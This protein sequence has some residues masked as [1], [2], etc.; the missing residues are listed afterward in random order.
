MNIISMTSGEIS[1]PV[2]EA[3]LQ[4][5]L[6]AINQN[7]AYYPIGEGIYSLREQ[8]ARHYQATQADIMPENVL[9]TAGA[10]HA[11]YSVLMKLLCQTTGKNEVIVPA[12]YWFSLP[13]LIRQ[14]GGKLVPL[15]TDPEDDYRIDPKRLEA[16][17]TPQT[18]LFV[19]VNPCN[20]SGKIYSV[21]EIEAIVGVLE[22]HPHVH[23]LADEIYEFICFE[24]HEFHAHQTGETAS[25]V[26]HIGS[27][28]SV[29]DRVTTVSGF[30]KSFSMAGWRV[31]YIVASESLIQRY[32]EYQDLTHAG[33]PIY[34]Q[35]AAEV[36][37]QERYRYLPDVLSQLDEKRRQGLAI[38]KAI[39]GIKCVRPQ[40]T[41]YFF[42]DVSAFY[43]S[44]DHQGNP[45]TNSVD[46][47]RYLFTDARVRV[48]PGEM[49]GNTNHLRISFGMP[50]PQMIEGLQRVTVSLRKLSKTDRPSQVTVPTHNANSHEE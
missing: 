45:I 21:D 36:A 50:R 15:P 40:G 29:A 38:F 9:I 20:P 34:T 8:I 18:R 24:G 26:A 14:A 28:Q 3:V 37:W 4:A 31:G 13:D 43:G 46:M 44:L 11:M 12:P 22:K 47:A 5:G 16:L 19:L 17:I 27:W 23:I 1:H 10:R 35:K 41:Y 49:F 6:E 39:E 30:S 33:V 2:P 25:C 7:L 32:R 42:P 48:L